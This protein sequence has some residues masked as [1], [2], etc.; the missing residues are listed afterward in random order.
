MLWG[1]AG[2]AIVQQAFLGHGDAGLAADT[3]MAL[4]MS[5]FGGII[6]AALLK[7]N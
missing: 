5:G 2:T 7:E 6:A 4:V 3:Q 1:V